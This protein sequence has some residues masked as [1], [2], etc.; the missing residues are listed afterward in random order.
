MTE[1]NF[2]NY[3][4]EWISAQEFPPGKQKALLAASELF[5]QQGY[6]ATSTAQIAKKAGISEA[7]I[8]KYFKTKKA[9]LMTV[10]SPMSDG[11]IPSIQTDFW[12]DFKQQKFNSATDLLHALVADRVQ[13]FQQN[14]VIAPILLDQLLVN[15]SLRDQVRKQ[16]FN[17][18]EGQFPTFNQSFQTLYGH[19]FPRNLKLETIFVNLMRLLIGDFIQIIV[20]DTVDQIDWDHEIDI[21]TQQLIVSLPQK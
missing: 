2:T 1:K 10:L 6:D 5:S 18:I 7:T 14:I 8:F 19:L 21:L 9:L 17:T 13:Y 20:L 11:L 4:A 16:I 15:P 3:F 12:N